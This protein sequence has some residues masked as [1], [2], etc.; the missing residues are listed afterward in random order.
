MV[1]DAATVSGVSSEV[2]AVSP[3]AT[4]ASLTAVTRIVES[5]VLLV[6]PNVVFVTDTLIR[7]SAV[8]GASELF[9]NVMAARALW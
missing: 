6:V 9:A 1:G 5:A 3:V 7:R 4:G 2:V 8:F